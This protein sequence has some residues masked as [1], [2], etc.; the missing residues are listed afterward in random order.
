VTAPEWWRCRSAWL[1]AELESVN[2]RAAVAFASG[3][4]VNV[5]AGYL[6]SAH[7]FHDCWANF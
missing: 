6:L 2:W 4:V 3:A 7:V 1:P 5:L